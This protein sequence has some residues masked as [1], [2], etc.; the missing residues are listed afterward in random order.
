MRQV[1]VVLGE[2]LVDVDR[3][4]E[5]VGHRLRGLHRAPLRAA[6]QAGDREARQ[7]VGQPLGL[8]DALLG[9]VG[10]GTLPGFTAERQRM[11]D[12]KQL[13]RDTI[14]PVRAFACPVCNDFA[15]FESMRC[16]TCHTALGLHL[17]TKSM[18]PV[19]DGDAA[20]R[21]AALGALHQSRTLG[22]NWLAPEE[23]AAYERGR[24]LADSLIRRE[25]AADDTL[26][27]EKLVPT[28][29]AL[30]RLVYQLD[31]IGLP[32]DP[33][34]RARRRPGVRPA[35]QLQHRREGHHRPRQRR[36]HDRPRR[37]A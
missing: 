36:H 21:R 32:I 37:I 12:E 7:R 1:A 15:S 29:R 30:R 20:D 17:P 9:Q 25:P 35:V 14:W 8:L 28:A 31:D 27:R 6:D 22:C 16:P 34:W 23:Q 33:F 18:V 11:P 4:P 19:T 5:R 13:H 26:A 2:P 3:Q 24:C 10:V